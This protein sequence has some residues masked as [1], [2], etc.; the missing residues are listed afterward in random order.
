MYTHVLVYPHS[1]IRNTYETL[2]RILEARARSAV[3][4]THVGRLGRRTMFGSFAA[5]WTA[6]YAI[7]DFSSFVSA[8]V[9]HP[10]GLLHMH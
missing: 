3:G 9:T 4:G 2:A 8:K 6:P 10:A 1:C 7:S 5:T